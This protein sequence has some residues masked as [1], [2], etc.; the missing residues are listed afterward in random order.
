MFFSKIEC[1]YPIHSRPLFI[2][3]VL[4]STITVAVAWFLLSKDYDNAVGHAEQRN[5][6]LTQ[7]LEENARR[8]L[9]LSKSSLFDLSRGII[10]NEQLTIS[11]DLVAMMKQWL[12]TAPLISSYWVFN[13]RGE[14]IYTTQS[15]TTDGV[16]F[17]DRSYFR[18]HREGA[19]IYVGEVTLGRLDGKWFFSLSKRLVDSHG[20]FRGVILASMSADYFTSIYQK[21]GLGVN[22]N[23]GIFRYDGSVIARRLKNFS[24]NEI[25][26]NTNPP[27][28]VGLLPKP[29]G[30]YHA[31]SPIDN[32]ERILSYRTVE[33]WPL[34]VVSGTA[35]SD[36]IDDWR[37]RAIS[38]VVF[39]VTLLIVIWSA[40]VW[41]LHIERLRM[42]EI[43]EANREILVAKVAAEKAN[44]AKSRFLASASHDLRQPL[45]ALCFYI[46]YLAQKVGRDHAATFSNIE[47]CIAGF[48]SLLTDLIELARL[49][50]Q[51]IKPRYS[52]FS[53]NAVFH[54]VRAANLSIA[55]KKG[56][57]LSIV[58]TKLRVCTDEALFGRILGNLVNNAVSYTEKGGVVVGCRRRSGKV[59]IEVYDSGIGIPPDKLDSIFEE[60]SQLAEQHPNLERGSGLGLAIVRRSATMLGIEVKVASKLGKGT[61]F[62]V[63]AKV[64]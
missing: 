33:G 52:E 44:A 22:D 35:V 9:D 39:C 30:V 58:D 55:E 46:E 17:S 43:E 3:A 48:Q 42:L 61:I 53:I 62:S 59:W 50:A 21:L 64:V 56:I 36:I 16:N 45:Q 10:E 54:R 60:F 6:V 40:V 11:P 5:L 38:A 2:I 41:G 34:V 19:D 51:V 32:I 8:A 1:I 12:G 63:E 14:A 57:R 26:T 47:Q 4:F 24:R 28:F 49:D 13:E 23:V 25:P 20:V 18:A 7:V 31:I 15:L 37:P 29:A 27:K